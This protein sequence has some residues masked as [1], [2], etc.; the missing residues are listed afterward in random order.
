[1]TVLTTE[2]RSPVSAAI[3]LAA[4][5]AL[6]AIPSF[7]AEA[8]QSTTGNSKPAVAPTAPVTATQ[9]APAQPETPAVTTAPRSL[10]PGVG[11]GTTPTI[12]Q[13]SQPP[14]NGIGQQPRGRLAITNL[15][16]PGR[17]AAGLLTGTN[18]G[19]SADL[20]QGTS[21][22]RITAILDRIPRVFRSG[23]ARQIARKLY[24][25]AGQPPA[26]YSK[27]EFLTRRIARLTDL[28]YF[29]DAA[30]LGQA[31][32][33]ARRSTE[34]A[35]EIFRADLLAG[36]GTTTCASAIAYTEAP[37]TF[38]QQLRAYCD[39][40]AGRG[41]EAELVL[42]LLGE[43]PDAD[44]DFIALAETLNTQEKVSIAFSD[45][46]SPISIALMRRH[47]LAEFSDDALDL[48]PE[49]AARARAIFG[50]EQLSPEQKAAFALHALRFAGLESAPALL[51]LKS[52]PTQPTDYKGLLVTAMVEPD[53]PAKAEVLASAWRQAMAA[54][55]LDIAARL[56]KGFTA[57]LRPGQG[58][59]FLAADMVQILALNG[60]IGAAQQWLQ[61]LRRLSVAGDETARA[62]LITLAPIAL[63]LENGRGGTSVLTTWS[64]NLNTADAGQVRARTYLALEALGV[65]IPEV[66]WNR[67]LLNPNPNP[68]ASDVI[69]SDWALWRN[70]VIPAGSGQAGTAVAASLAL[71]GEQGPA[72]M[73][74]VGI[75]TIAGALRNLGLK[76]EA[77]LLVLE[78]L[79]AD[80]R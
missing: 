9:P 77:R 8:Q 4:L 47:A 79:I 26:G 17:D 43:A 1:M 15:T 24:L 37:E 11:R 61:V 80:M 16:S 22:A 19:L 71:I 62:R 29:S 50:Q 72:D 63:I 10:L 58:Y 6:I 2:R 45:T 44:Q 39:L 23:A 41:A 36:R 25:S 54:A 66:L 48:G 32:T 67:E 35:I 73:E 40:I 30:S 12:N 56:S 60:E 57:S 64:E 20:W 5:S 69:P 75:A 21:A 28:G 46:L 38:L 27:E 59:D 68:D 70:V 78:T 65:T 31:G 49:D 14:G 34:T 51:A 3:R 7:V 13:G 52:L 53:G 76:D 18:G 55:E 42:S 74:P 33:G